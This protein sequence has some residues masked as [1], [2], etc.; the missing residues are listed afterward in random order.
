MENT[1]EFE[2]AVELE[3]LR[4]ENAELKRQIDSLLTMVSQMKNA[5]V[6]W[7]PTPQ[8]EPHYPIMK[9]D[10]WYTDDDSTYGTITQIIPQFQSEIIYGING[11]TNEY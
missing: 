1:P 3:V 9:P 4:R 11:Q 10:I 2:R 6:M 5:P 8:P 7:I